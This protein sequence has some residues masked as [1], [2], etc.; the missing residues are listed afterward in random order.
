MQLVGLGNFG[1][2]RMRHSIGSMVVDSV[3]LRLGAQWV[4]DQECKGYVAHTVPYGSG[5][6]LWLLK[7]RLFMN[8]CGKSVAKAGACMRVYVCAY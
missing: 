1:M 2:K 3:A 5:N 4:L 6:E 8:E 7:P